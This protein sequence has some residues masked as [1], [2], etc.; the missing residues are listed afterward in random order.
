MSIGAGIA[1]AG[2]FIAF[3][4]AASVSENIAAGVI[5]FGL[6]AAAAH[7]IGKA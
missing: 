6:I 3:V 7:H 2:W 1:V 5:V 4:W